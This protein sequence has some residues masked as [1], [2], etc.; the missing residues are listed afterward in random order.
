MAIIKCKNCKKNDVEQSEDGWIWCLE[1]NDGWFTNAVL[2]YFPQL[3]DDRL[4]DFR[5]AW[6]QA[7]RGPIRFLGKKAEGRDDK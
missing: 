2:T 1:C 3:C 4:S 6:A 7:N 5:A